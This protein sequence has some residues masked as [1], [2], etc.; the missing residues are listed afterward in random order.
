MKPLRFKRPE[1]AHI[2]LI[3][4][5][6]PAKDEQKARSH[7]FDPIPGE[8]V[9]CR[10]PCSTSGLDGMVSGRRRGDP[11]SGT[12][13]KEFF[14]GAGYPAVPAVFDLDKFELD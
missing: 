2:S 4:G 7:F 12:A 13:Q 14:A 3:L 9:T 11:G 5:E 8:W 10:K 6:E 1:F